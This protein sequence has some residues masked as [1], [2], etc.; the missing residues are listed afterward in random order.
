M[1]TYYP[2]MLDLLSKKVVVIGGGKV[3]ERKVKGLKEAGANVVIVAPEV[4]TA[5][6]QLS[7]KAEVTWLKKPFSQ[8]DVEGALL[9]IAATNKQ[10]V[11][12]AVARAVK[13]NQLLNVVDAP[14]KSTFHVPAVMRRGKLSIAVSTSGASPVLAKKICKQISETY[15]QEFET[16]IDFLYECRQYIVKTID[17][18][19][20]RRQLLEAVAEESF[21]K[22][23]DW[24][25]KLQELLE[26][27]IGK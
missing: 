15:G 18:P 24:E 8:E 19:I 23:M 1:K 6:R 13:P 4:T 17:N 5:L 10:E 12:E 20:K 27:T 7:E 25:G 22:S 26:K 11:N 14:E 9:V 3:A 21:R 16:Y 2:I